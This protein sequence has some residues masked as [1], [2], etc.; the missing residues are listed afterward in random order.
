MTERLDWF[1]ADILEDGEQVVHIRPTLS[2]NP[3]DVI[4]LDRGETRLLMA[5]LDQIVANQSL[6]W[7]ETRQAILRGFVT[8]L[9]PPA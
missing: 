4:E 9:R 5:I 7:P 1:T 6:P 8:A 2:K 3:T